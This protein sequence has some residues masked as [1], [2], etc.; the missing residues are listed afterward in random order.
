MGMFCGSS[1]ELLGCGSGG[2]G[3]AAFGAIGVGGV[4]AEVV[5]TGG[6]EAALSSALTEA[7][8]KFTKPPNR[9]CGQQ[10]G[11][12]PK[13]GN[14]LDPRYFRCVQA[15]F[16]TRKEF[17]LIHNAKTKDRLYVFFPSHRTRSSKISV[18]P[19]EV[20]EIAIKVR[21]NAVWREGFINEAEPF[22]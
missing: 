14:H 9:K 17:R 18:S 16:S 8:Q 1:V 12:Q 13:W 22:R 4:G 21:A 7:L 20:P 11:G 5:G 6:A 2:D 10:H 15:C 19:L 3:G